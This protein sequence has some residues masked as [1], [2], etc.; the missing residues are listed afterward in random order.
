MERIHGVLAHA[1]TVGAIPRNFKTVHHRACIRSLAR[2][3]RRGAEISGCDGRRAAHCS[4]VMRTRQIVEADFQLMRRVARAAAHSA[5][6][7][8]SMFRRAEATP[9]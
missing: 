5:R 7:A 2:I 6:R 9:D 1:Y 8:A 4:E 3:E